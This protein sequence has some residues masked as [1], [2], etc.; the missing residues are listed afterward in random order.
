MMQTM[1]KNMKLVLWILVIAFIA[2]IIFSWGMGGFQ[3]SG[4]KQ[5]IAAVINGKQITTDHLENLYQQR[6]QYLQSQSKDTELTEEQVKQ[7][8]T[9]VWDELL[10]DILMEQEVRRLGIKATDQEIAYLIQN[11]PPDYIRDNEYFQTDGQFDMKK[12]EQFLRNPQAARDLM[13]IEDNYRK[14]LPSQKFINELIS[15]ATV[16]D[17][18]AWQT[19]SQDNLRG[20]ARFVVFYMDTI[21]VD[22]NSISRKEMEDYYNAHKEDYR[23]KEKRRAAYVMFKNDPSAADTVS[24]LHQAEDLKLRLEQGED[25]AELAKDYSD[26]PSK[27]NGGDMDFI[28]KGSVIK[29]FGEAA[30]SAPVGQVVGPVKSEYGYH[31]IK[32]LEKKTE[33]G[34]EQAHVLHILLNVKAS[35]DTRD[36]V[37]NNVESFVEEGQKSS[38]EN[39]A[40]MYETNA[41]TTQW[42]DHGTFIA[43]LGKLPAAVDF[44]FSRPVGQTTGSYYVQ[45]AAVIFKTIGVQPERILPFS[46]VFTGVRYVLTEKRKKEIAHQRGE[47]FRQSVSDPTQFASQAQ[48]KGLQVF[49]TDLEFKQNDYVPNVGRDPAFTQA[50]LSLDVGVVSHPVDGGHGCYVIQSTARILPDTTQFQGER[51]DIVRRL[52]QTKQNEIYSN[53][54]EAA[55]KKAKIEDYRYL[56]YRD[57]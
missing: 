12:Y 47:Q 9:Q 50:A 51:D 31:L 21:Q 46:E 18:E 7:V 56:Y 8:R 44:I 38:F 45:D 25:W 24:T 32:V 43:G 35:S 17:N 5:G 14:S 33:N 15:M 11:S 2:T 1:R 37:S 42:F 53:W 3:G 19:F 26:D 36:L 20:K 54:L 55:K 30:F 49:E 40:R 57:Y 23:V 34:E 48:S 27:N 6:L 16:S 13:T 22:T 28:S 10:R 39:A 4:P 29:E 52:M 41:D